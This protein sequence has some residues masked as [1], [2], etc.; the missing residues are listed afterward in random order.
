MTIDWPQ[1]A[2]VIHTHQR[3]VLTSHL[4]PDCDALGS[5]LG[6]AG[7]LDTLGKEVLI[8]NADPTPRH[9]QF[10]DPRNR[11]LVLGRDVVAQQ[12]ADFDLMMVLDTS[13]WG[14]LGAMGEVLRNSRAAKAVLDHH[15]SSD[16]LGAAVFKDT[17]AEATGRLVVEAAHALLLPL[18]AEVARPL[19]AAI[20]TD[21]GWFRFTSVSAAT[22]KAAAD[23]VAAGAEP[24]QLYRD[25]YE[26]STLARVHLT[27]EA[28]RKATLE[29]DGKL[30]WSMLT[31]AEFNQTGASPADTEELVNSLLRVAGTQ[32]AILFVEQPA[33]NQFKVSFRSR[34]D[35]FD[36]SD[37]AEAFGGGGHKAA[38]GAMITG[39]PAAV[40]EKV[41]P[42]VKKILRQA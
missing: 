16:D 20:A 25:L 13:S 12:L 4:R 38:S 33:G 31:S 15:Q 32:A 40:Q 41:L 5:E 7:L 6:M 37:V 3:F 9:L 39:D 24:D 42:Y 2:E 19:F 23:L 10:I 11:I 21:T 8:V 30:I 35:A 36:C 14:Q 17:T 27:G 28:L 18:T 34:I 26:Q 22:F 29:L 1:F